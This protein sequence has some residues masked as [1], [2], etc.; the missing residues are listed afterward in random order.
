[1]PV[2]AEVQLLQENASA[3]TNVAKIS[4][5][6]IDQL[7]I[8]HL[9]SCI[10]VLFLSTIVVLRLSILILRFVLIYFISVF[11][12]IVALCSELLVSLMIPM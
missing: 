4:E 9:F 10:K 2:W 5:T 3:V 8:S 6:A 12:N 1:M 11:A 7:D